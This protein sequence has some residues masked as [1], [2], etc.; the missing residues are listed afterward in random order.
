MFQFFLVM[1][2]FI[3]WLHGHISFL[4]LN[5]FLANLFGGS[6]E[7]FESTLFSAFDFKDQLFGGDMF[8]GSNVDHAVH[9][10]AR[11]IERQ[12]CLHLNVTILER[13]AFVLKEFHLC[14][15]LLVILFAPYLEYFII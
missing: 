13:T 14:F 5:L 15:I 6:P 8:L 9:A 10:R 3:N 7:A 12:L 2:R 1:L 4:I 11:L